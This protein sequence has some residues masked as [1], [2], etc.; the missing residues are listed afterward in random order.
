[1]KLQKASVCVSILFKSLHIL[2]SDVT[3]KFDKW[4]FLNSPNVESH[5]SVNFLCSFTLK[6]LIQAAFLSF[7][8]AEVLSLAPDN[9]HLENSFAES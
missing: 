6:S 9:G 7:A 8:Y 2:F 1:M 5:V 3:P 4:H